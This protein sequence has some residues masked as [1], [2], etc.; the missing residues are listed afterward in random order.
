MMKIRRSKKYL[1]YDVHEVFGSQGDNEINTELTM[2]EGAPAL[3]CEFSPVAPAR[4]ILNSIEQHGKGLGWD[5]DVAWVLVRAAS[6]H[7]LAIYIEQF[8]DKM[9]E[10]Y[11]EL[12]NEAIVQALCALNPFPDGVEFEPGYGALSNAEFTKSPFQNPC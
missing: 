11:Y 7:A 10:A 1:K 4:A 8:H 6:Q 5:N 12:V 9:E 3:R 2:E